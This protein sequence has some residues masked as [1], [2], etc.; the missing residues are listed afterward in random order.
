MD[1]LVGNDSEGESLGK[2]YLIALAGWAAF[3]LAAYGIHKALEPSK[4]EQRPVPARQAT[5]IETRL[6]KDAEF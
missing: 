5:G 6:G 2:K 3:G 1:Y 4:P